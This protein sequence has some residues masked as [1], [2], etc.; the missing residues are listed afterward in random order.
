MKTWLSRTVPWAAAL[1]LALPALLPAP[2][3]AQAN[4]R[5]FPETG[6]TVQGTF[7]EEAENRITLTEKAR[8]WDN[9]GSTLADDGVAAVI[10]I[11]SPFIEFFAA[12][13][14]PAS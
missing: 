4:S 14:V 12:R 7:L 2:I 11:G 3:Q 1:A 13:R 10:E 5:T 8:V 6:K 9:T